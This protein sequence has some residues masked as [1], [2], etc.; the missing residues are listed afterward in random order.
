MALDALDSYDV[1]VRRVTPL[2]HHLNLLYRVDTIAGERY[3]LRISNPTWRSLV[4]LRSE[5][6]WLVALAR[7]TDIGAHEP[8][9]NRHGKHVTTVDIDGVPEPRRCVLFTWVPGVELA[10]CLTA[11]NVEKLGVL[12]AGLHEHAKGFTPGEAFT[13]RKL[14]RLFPRDEVCVLFAREHQHLFSPDQ[15]VTFKQAMERAQS[16]L[17]R[18]YADPDGLRVIHGD[19]HHENVKVSRGRLRPIDF[20]DVIWGYPIQ[21]IALTFY[22]FRFY[23][24]PETHDYAALCGAFQCGYTSNLPWPQEYP[25]QIDTLHVA[26]RIWVANWVLQNADAQHHQPFIDRLAESFERFLAG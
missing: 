17:D 9:P 11:D 10:E 24:D 18:L 25:D 23:T 19:L 15:R 1:D 13:S 2:T 14:D 16:E 20:E 6:E 26:R 21:D 8:V 22:D 7:D 5:L 4:E 3:A 12:S